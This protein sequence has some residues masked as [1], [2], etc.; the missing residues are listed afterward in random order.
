MARRPDLIDTLLEDWASW[1][2]I[3]HSLEFGTGDSSIVRFREPAST[4]SV[5]SVP[6]WQ[7]RR[8]GRK[9]LALDRDLALRLGPKRVVLLIALYGMA[10]PIDR[11]AKALAIT[12][13]NL[14]TLRRHARRIALE[15][16]SLHL[17]AEIVHRDRFRDRRKEP[18]DTARPLPS[19]PASHSGG[20][21]SLA[22]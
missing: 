3:Y 22:D 21:Q 5:G 2:V 14:Q 17:T 11:K 16:V 9:L 19:V 1:R 6:L 20:T 4:R 15:H 13:N 8:T 7:G 18:N 10:G 12:V